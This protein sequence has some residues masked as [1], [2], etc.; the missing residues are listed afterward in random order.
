MKKT[1]KWL[2]IKGCKSSFIVNKE[3]FWGDDRCEDS[4]KWLSKN[5]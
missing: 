4:I 2:K 3:V 5:S 1:Q